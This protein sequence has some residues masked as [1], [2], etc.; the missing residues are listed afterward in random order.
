[1]HAAVLLFF[2]TRGAAWA[3][4][5]SVGFK[6][7][8][9]A[10]VYRFP[11]EI[12]SGAVQEGDSLRTFGKLI[13]YEPEESM[14]TLSAQHSSKDH[15][16][17]VHTKFVE[18]FDA[19]IGAQYMVFGELEKKEGVRAVICARVLNC[20]DGINVALLQKAIQDQRRF[21]QKRTTTQLESTDTADN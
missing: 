8:P 18:P 19:I 15:C 4:Q 11:W 17:A 9:S 3:G 14:A 16:V 12:I 1:M 7:L 2:W 21:F 5:R 6:M 13:R 10:T 20:V